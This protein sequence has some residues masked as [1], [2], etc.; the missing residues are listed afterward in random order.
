MAAPSVLQE[1]GFLAGRHGFRFANSFPE[2][3]VFKFLGRRFAPHEGCATTWR[4]PALGAAIDA[5]LAPGAA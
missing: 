2:T 5:W 3:P 1:T 4:L